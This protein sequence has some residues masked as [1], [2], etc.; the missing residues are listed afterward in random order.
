MELSSDSRSPIGST[1]GESNLECVSLLSRDRP[2][3]RCRRRRRRHSS[4]GAWLGANE[5][6]P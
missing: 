4:D 5:L 6:S 3:F 2:R 1:R